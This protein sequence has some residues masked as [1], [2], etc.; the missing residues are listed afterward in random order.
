MTDLMVVALRQCRCDIANLLR[1]RRVSGIHVLLHALV[2]QRQHE[3]IEDALDL[4]VGLASCNDK[5]LTNNE[6]HEVDGCMSE[7]IA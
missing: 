5:A 6:S 4:I 7:S 3:H 2:V 1:A